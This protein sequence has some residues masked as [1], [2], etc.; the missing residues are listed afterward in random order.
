MY[1]V[2]MQDLG[3]E[4]MSDITASEYADRIKDLPWDLH[5]SIA[6]TSQ[7]T[8]DAL[9]DAKSAEQFKYVLRQQLN[10]ELETKRALH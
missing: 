3:A 8:R 2:T 1:H 9:E 4:G 6:R 5:T 10:A 7:S